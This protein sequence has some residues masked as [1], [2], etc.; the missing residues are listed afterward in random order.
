M[1]EGL[2][3]AGT[4]GTP[5]TASAAGRVIVAGWSGGY[6]NLVV[7]DHGGGISTA[8]AH[9]SSIA[10]SIGQQV[11]QCTV[12]AGMGTTDNST[13]V[14]SHLE[15]RVNGSAVDPLGYL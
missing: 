15:I 4:S 12:L 11:A 10:V 6:G 14:H 5:I 3:I 8:Y 2:D 7:V 9:N 1:H 13:G